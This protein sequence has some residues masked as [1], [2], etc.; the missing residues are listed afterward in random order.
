MHLSVTSP[1]LGAGASTFVSGTDIEGDPWA[2]PPSMGC[3]EVVSS[4]LVGP[5]S[6][7]VQTAQ[8][9]LLVN[10]S[11]PLT[12]LI[13]GRASRLE[14]TFGDG[15]I[16]TNLSFITTHAWT[17]AGDYTV[18]C[19]AYN[20]DNP[21]GVSGDV[22]VHVLPLI[23]PLIETPCV[24]NNRFQ[25]QFTGQSNATYVL[26]ITTNLAP[27]IAWQTLQTLSCTG[28]VVQATDPAATNMTQ[29]YRVMAQ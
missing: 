23:Q 17:N 18:T 28:G 7:T 11:L 14:W 6:V 4:A 12:G 15:P 1:C 2:N 16:A 10:R 19:T 29:F 9:S 24:A 20:N 27:P 8:A 5:L 21:S 13:T 25:F 3:D 26:Q 22:L